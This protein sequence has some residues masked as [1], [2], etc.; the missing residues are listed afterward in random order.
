MMQMRGQIRVSGIKML[1]DFSVHRSLIPS[2]FVDNLDTHQ[3]KFMDRNLNIFTFTQPVE[4]LNTIFE[5]IKA[6]NPDFSVRRWAQVSGVKPEALLAVLKGKKQAPLVLMNDLLKQLDLS[7]LEQNYIEAMIKFS[8]AQTAPE[9]EMFRLVLDQL[10]PHSSNEALIE[11]ESLF[12]HW[13][14]L[15][16]FVMAGMETFVC[17]EDSI[18]RLFLSDVPRSIIKSGIQKLLFTQMVTIDEHGVLRK[19]VDHMG[20]QNDVKKEA[21]HDYYEQVFDMAKA[22]IQTPL[23][24][25]EFQCLTVSL[26]SEELAL[27]KNEIR[28]F[29][30]KL[31]TLSQMKTDQV[32]QLNVQFFPL[33]KK[34]SPMLPELQLRS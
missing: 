11:D 24:E 2:Q 5:I 3:G 19:T 21:I 25:R 13:S 22:H 29:R 10:R 8:S 14:Y 34:V 30:T 32:Y 7:A 6:T 26:N 12:S 4:L 1:E 28:K 18:A 23:D 27:F 31:T 9:K 20:T 16:I 15:A 17:T 33:T